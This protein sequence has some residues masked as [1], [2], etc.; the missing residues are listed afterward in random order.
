MNLQTFFVLQKKEHDALNESVTAK[1]I[2]TIPFAAGCKDPERTAITH[3]GTYLM[4]LKGFQK[5]CAHLP[6]DDEDIFNRL[7]CISTFEGGNKA[8]IEHGMY[9]L[10]LI[11]I[12]GYKKSMKKD[13]LENVYNP[14]NS[15]K[16][17]YKLLREFILSKINSFNCFNLDILIY[18][19][20]EKL[21]V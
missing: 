7:A 2:A 8:I 17:D 5:F 12:E 11:M 18:N 9:I 13:L 1:I 14:F 6:S 21:W 4:E 10:A 3:L 16:W 20:S 15:G 19:Y